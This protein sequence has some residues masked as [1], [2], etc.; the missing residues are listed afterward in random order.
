MTVE[1]SKS[2][3][4]L[5][6]VTRM[7]RNSPICR[8]AWLT[9]PLLVDVGLAFLLT[10]IL[11]YGSMLFAVLAIPMYSGHEYQPWEAPVWSVIAYSWRWDSGW[12]ASIIQHGYAQTSGQN[13]VAFFPLFPM[14]VRIAV[15]PFSLHWMFVAGVIVTNIALFLALIA[16]W[17]YAESYGGRHLAQRVLFLLAIFPAS[18]FFSVA[19]S[20]SVFL[21]VIA[22]SLLMLRWGRFAEAGAAG[23]F[24]ALAR[25]PGLYIGIPFVIEAWKQRRSTW[26]DLPRKLVWI[27][28]IPAGLGCFMLYLWW[29][30]G[31]P[32]LF[33]TAQGAWNHGRDSPLASLD[34]AVRQIF[35]ANGT[36]IA[37]FMNVVNTSAGIL[38][39]VLGIA[40]LRRNLA[41]G[42][43]VL[44]GVLAPLTFPISGASS[45]SLARYVVVLFPMFIPLARWAR[46]RPVLI[47][48]AIIFIPLQVIVAGLFLRWYWVI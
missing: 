47:A 45:I 35:M 19:Y 38:A 7:L 44:A 17:L 27:L 12:Y 43:F 31:D 10:K 1:T 32:F 21:L 8:P 48:L 37:Q 5:D 25:P 2:H 20:E 33:L 16:I 14:L 18:F 29:K 3:A 23:F 28:L 13:S 39:I 4:R 24:A 40:L 42:L 9:R 41:G 36:R 30:F 34:L 11:F 46:S 26:P 6:S 22:W 15:G